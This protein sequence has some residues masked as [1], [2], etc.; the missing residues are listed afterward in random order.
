MENREYQTWFM[1]PHVPATGSRHP[2]LS[3]WL[4]SCRQGD[5]PSACSVTLPVAAGSE[6]QGESGLQCVSSCSEGRRL[7]PAGAQARQGDRGAG[8]LE[9]PEGWQVV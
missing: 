1:R 4:W 3:S 9:V 5:V 7:S 6:L 2:G 8:W